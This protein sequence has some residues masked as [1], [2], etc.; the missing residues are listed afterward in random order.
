MIVRDVMTPHVVAAAPDSTVAEIAGLLL[1]HQV[2]GLPVVDEAGR[3][4]GMVSEGDLIRRAEIGTAPGRASWWLRVFG[5]RTALADAYVK[6]HARLARDVMTAPVVT[7]EETT[8]L[9]EAASL[10]A[11]HGIKR[12]PVVRDGRLA[13]IVSRANLVQALAAA[14]TPAPVAAGDGGLRLAVL[15]A[16][17]ELPWSSSGANGVTVADGVVEF[18]GVC[19]S[20]EE[21]R[22]TRIAA[23]TVPGIRGVRD[24]R[25][26]G[27]YLP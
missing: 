2:S 1:R 19:E 25:L 23:E 15:D 11:K 21:R 10:L 27:M 26:I 24:H 18:W 12:L 22:A 7:V 5:D 20:E 6:S 8:P 4:V 14:K 9:A 13:G 3:P 17:R 16:L